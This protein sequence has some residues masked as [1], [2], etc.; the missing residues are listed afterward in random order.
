MEESAWGDKAGEEH[1][2]TKVRAARALYMHDYDK[3]EVF[4]KGGIAE[5]RAKTG[6]GPTTTGWVDH[7]ESNKYRPMRVKRQFKTDR[8]DQ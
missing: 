8:A 4:D 6:Q 7:D 2:A 3:L 5:D 1:D